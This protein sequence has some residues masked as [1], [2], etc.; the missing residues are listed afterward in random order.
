MKK[1]IVFG[2]CHVFPI[3][4]YLM[5][6]HTFRYSYKLLEIL[7]IQGC[8]QEIGVGD[9]LLGECDLFIYMRTSDAY[10]PYLSSEYLLSKLPERCVKISIGNAYFKT[11]YPQFTFDNK[12]TLYGY[13]DQNVIRL[14]K[15]GE[16]KERIVALLSDEQFYSAQQLHIIHTDFMNNLRQ[17][18]IGIDIPL[19]NFIEQHYQKEHLFCTVCHPRYHI[20]RYLAMNILQRIG[21]S[22]LEIANAFYDVDFIDLIHP[23]YPSVIKHLN[24][25]F[26]QPGAR[27]YSLGDEKFSFQEYIARYV[28]IHSNE[29]QLV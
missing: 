3:R 16:S 24:L 18:E 5:S 19:A 6:S 23:I 29:L 20:I 1:C 17:R 9:H 2:N 10:G 25:K 21:I 11:Y 27:I 4:R 8:N 7:P 26:L 14:L 28:D 22:P 15:K 13:E 12:D